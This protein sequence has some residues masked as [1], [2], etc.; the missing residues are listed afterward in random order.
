[1][2]AK[3]ITLFFS[4]E[5][6]I[7]ELRGDLNKLLGIGTIAALGVIGVRGLIV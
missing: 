7:T 5:V 2:A 3:I 1:V 6:L 4:C